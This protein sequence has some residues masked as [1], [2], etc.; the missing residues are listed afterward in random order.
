MKI[1]FLAPQERKFSAWIGGSI[2][3]YLSTFQTMS[4]S[5]AE[6]KESGVQIVHKKCF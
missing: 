4:I 2:L 3:S 1:K 5:K 6:Y